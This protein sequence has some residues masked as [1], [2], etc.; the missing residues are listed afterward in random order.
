MSNVNKD[1]SPS[2]LRDR[3]HRT[4]SYLNAQISTTNHLPD[5][6][7]QFYLDILFNLNDQI[8]DLYKTI[9]SQGQ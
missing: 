5:N 6:T 3:C 7:K 4:L 2:I 8:D 1:V 9:Q